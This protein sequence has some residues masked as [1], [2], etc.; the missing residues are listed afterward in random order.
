LLPHLP[1]LAAACGRHGPLSDMLGVL[2]GGERDREDRKDKGRPPP[3][4]VIAEAYKTR[5]C[6]HFLDDNDCPFGQK[7]VFAHGEHDLKEPLKPLVDSSVVDSCPA[8]QNPK[9]RPE[10]YK[11]TLCRNWQDDQSCA[12]GDKCAFAH[13]SHELRL[14][15]AVPSED[16]PE[17]SANLMVEQL[18]RLLDVAEGRVRDYEIQMQRYQTLLCLAERDMETRFAQHVDM[19]LHQ[20]RLREEA[21]RGTLQKRVADLAAATLAYKDLEQQVA[22]LK[23]EIQWFQQKGGVDDKKH[24]SAKGPWL[25]H[26]AEEV[27]EWVH[28]VLEGPNATQF[29]GAVFDR[30]RAEHT[31]ALGMLE[32][33]EQE[34]KQVDA[35]ASRLFSTALILRDR[36][37][38]TM[39]Q[40]GGDDTSSMQSTSMISTSSVA[41]KIEPDTDADAVSQEL[42]P[43][44]TVAPTIRVKI[45]EVTQESEGPCVSPA[46]SSDSALLPFK[47]ERSSTPAF[48]RPSKIIR[49]NGKVI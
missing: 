20:M 42:M 3:K 38:R 1:S 34:Q 43:L 18:L 47:R 2:H 8:S 37:K 21:L 41:V 26:S 39:P 36:L 9:N 16:P 48:S 44:P 32:A 35:R 49:K 5:L 23:T 15:V 25:T 28:G 7:C 12:F 14:K 10:A 31:E 24:A 17:I 30:L 13:G 6:R 40:E 27:L 45:E 22:S 33:V 4:P 46:T 11:T 19:N 29:R